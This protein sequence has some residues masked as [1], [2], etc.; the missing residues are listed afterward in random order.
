MF[1]EP[2]DKYLKGDNIEIYASL[3]RIISYPFLIGG[4][5]ARQIFLNER[6][7]STDIDIYTDGYY[8]GKI[9]YWIKKNTIIASTSNSYTF[10]IDGLK[11]QLIKKIQTLNPLSLFNTYD[12]TCCMFAVGSNGYIYYTDLAKEHA[13]GKWLYIANNENY[14]YSRIGKYL[15]KGYAPLC[16]IS[17]S[18]FVEFVE[19]CNQYR[20]PN[21]KYAVFD[22]G[23]PITK[24]ELSDKLDELFI[25]FFGKCSEDY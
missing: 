23:R 6:L 16:P 8:Y 14:T 17:Q 12:F 21:D 11:I 18:I 9:Y 24:E 25:N 3:K 5:A 4:G 22:T 7:G 20:V 13:L 15:K 2:L 1:T 10:N 19:Y